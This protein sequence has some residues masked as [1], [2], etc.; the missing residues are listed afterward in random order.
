MQT[1]I[2]DLKNA[3]KSNQPLE[4]YLN[5]NSKYTW[6][7]NYPIAIVHEYTRVKEPDTLAKM[8]ELYF[9]G[10]DGFSQDMYTP[11][12]IEFLNMQAPQ[13]IKNASLLCYD[14]PLEHACTFKEKFPHDKWKKVL[15]NHN[16][17]ATV[18][19]SNFDSNA[20]I[21]EIETELRDFMRS[22][23]E[24][25]SLKKIAFVWIVTLPNTTD[26][27]QIMEHYFLD[28]YASITDENTTTYI[29]WN[30]ILNNI[31]LRYFVVTPK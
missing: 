19:I 13:Y 10:D 25:P 6:Q 27:T 31:N 29:G 1:I 3:L 4:E 2:Q 30:E 20:S 18:E 9:F 24:I 28:N 12:M 11:K 22:R 5:K 26:I 8:N 23:K 7:K 17:K 16:F 21:M 15:N 14:G